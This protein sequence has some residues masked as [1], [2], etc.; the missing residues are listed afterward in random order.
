MKDCAQQV[1]YTRN[2]EMLHAQVGIKLIQTL[3]EEYPELFD[4]ELQ[5]RVQEECIEALKAESKVIDWIMDGYSAPGLSADILKA[6]I[7]KRMSESIDA[8]VLG[9]GYISDVVPDL[10]TNIKVTSTSACTNSINIPVVPAFQTTTTTTTLP[11]P[12][13]TFVSA[14]YNNRIVITY[15]NCSGNLQT[16]EHF[17]TTGTCTKEICARLIIG[18]SEI[19]TNTGPCIL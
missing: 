16:L 15:I 2:E 12:C 10:T 14:P 4:E 7:A 6:F 1:Q 8:I 3:R 5:A 17:C 9:G 19:M 18:A 11:P 13:Y